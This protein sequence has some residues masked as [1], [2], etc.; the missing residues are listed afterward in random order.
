MG[1]PSPATDYAE[2]RLTLDKICGVDMNCRLIETDLGWALI[3]VSLKPEPNEVVLIT[4]DG[5]N[6]FVRLMGKALI[7]ED[8]EA[9]EGDALDDVIVHGVL[10]HT[11][12][13]VHHD[14]CPV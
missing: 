9:M 7:L 5:Q 12:T 1:F 6:H 13:S 11:F 10:T 14:K 4:Y 3:N 2:D 8:G